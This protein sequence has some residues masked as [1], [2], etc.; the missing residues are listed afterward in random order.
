MKIVSGFDTSSE[1]LISTQR[2]SKC[3]GALRLGSDLASKLKPREAE[4]GGRSLEKIIQNRHGPQICRMRRQKRERWIKH[5]YK[6]FKLQ[7]HTMAE[8]HQICGCCRGL[9]ARQIDRIRNSSRWALGVFLLIL[10]VL[11]WVGSA[12]LKNHKR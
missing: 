7:F 4:W 10:V 8:S 3:Y 6:R 2:K 1:T 5:Q 9:I 12:S 11:I